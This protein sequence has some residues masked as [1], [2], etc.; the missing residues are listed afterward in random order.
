[1]YQLN[2][3][4]NQYTVQKRK[5]VETTPKCF[6]RP[7]YAHISLTNKCNLKYSYCYADD[8]N[9]TCDMTVE[10]VLHI[11]DLCNEKGVFSISWTGGEPFTRKDFPFLLNKAYNF[12]IHQTILTNGTCISEGFFEETPKTNISYQFSLNKAWSSKEEDKINHKKIFENIRICEKLGIPNVVTIVAEPTEEYQIEKLMTELIDNGVKMARLGFLMP[13]GKSQEYYYKSYMEKMKKSFT[14]YNK[15]KKKYIDK[16]Q[17]IY[18]FDKDIYCNNG[19]PRRFFLCEAGT[20]LMYID[21]N[22]DVY[23][24]P[25]FKSRQDFRCGNILK[26]D[27][28]ILWKSEPMERLRL[29][30]ECQDCNF[31]CKTWCRASKYF[32]G[33]KIEG[34]SMYCLKYI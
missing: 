6:Q 8:Q 9:D 20:T 10:E 17:I 34:K 32:Y 13:I 2:N 33:E 5:S 7:I 25:L 26:D 16:I 14:I 24:C 30:P 31:L 4:I 27:W 1:M 21:N 18:Q 22:G 11:I 19:I 3:G 28:D 29:I 12:G 23:P 15:I